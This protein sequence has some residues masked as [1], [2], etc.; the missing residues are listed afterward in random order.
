VFLW[1]F[2]LHGVT[3]ANINILWAL[4]THPVLAWAIVARARWRWLWPYLAG[5][6]V[7]AAV[8]L[9]GWTLW[10]QEI[11]AE[12]VPLLLAIIARSGGLA[13][14]RRGLVSTA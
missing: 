8:V 13:V 6:A 14:V 12:V 9:L 4:P 5:S 10:K 3:K 2:S 7:L 11:P 1:F